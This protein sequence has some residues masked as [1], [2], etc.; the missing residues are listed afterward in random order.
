MGFWVIGLCSVRSMFLY[1]LLPKRHGVGRKRKKR[2]KKKKKNKVGSV[3]NSALICRYAQSL[4]PCGTSG[5][6]LMYCSVIKIAKCSLVK[7]PRPA[8]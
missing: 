3:D 1:A 4:G 5:T 8:Y 7:G 2:K 6:L